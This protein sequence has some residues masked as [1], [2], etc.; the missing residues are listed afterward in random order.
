M[1]GATVV[2]AGHWDPH[3][4]LYRLGTDHQRPKALIDKDICNWDTFFRRVVPAC[5]DDEQ[6]QLLREAEKTAPR[7]GVDFAYR[8]NMAT[9]FCCPSI[10]Y[11]N[12]LVVVQGRATGQTA[13]RPRS[14]SVC[15]PPNMDQPGRLL[16]GAIHERALPI[17]ALSIPLESNK[18]RQNNQVLKQLTFAG[19]KTLPSALRKDMWRPLFTATFPSPSQGLAAFR[20]LRELRMLHEHNWEHPDPDARKLPEK[21]ER[22]RLIMD[23]KANSIA[24]LAW[25]LRGQE[26]LGVKMAEKHEAN[27]HRIREEL[28]ALSKEAEEGGV[29][30]LEQTLADQQ[31]TID[32]MKQMQQQG[33]PD[34]PSRKQ[35]GEAILVSKQMRLRLEK[36]RAA[37]QAIEDAKNKAQTQFETDDA[38]GS[39][40]DAIS[41]VIEPPR[42]FS[43]PPP[44]LSS[45]SKK[46]K[47]SEQVPLYTTEGVIIRWTNPL[48]AEF[49]AEWPAAVQHEFAGLAR[50]TA[51]PIDQEPAFSVE[52]M[53]QRNTSHKY[54]AMRDA[55]QGQVEE[56][57]EGVEDVDAADYEQ[58]TEKSAD[59]LAPARQ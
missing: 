48:D 59:G 36:M 17:A 24:D 55:R 32:N 37:S 57:S 16:T 27:Q 46:S 33:G 51:A 47:S 31:A 30:L 41:L 11:H 5:D 22:G 13:S 28:L 18:V 58:V 1:E 39:A 10:A 54:T 14:P 4:A 40:P 15:L 8:M 44:E 26:E 43:H 9:L 7:P 42:I 38:R 3:L 35:I 12:V 29:Q 34:A 52:D 45:K 49:A 50:H 2:L 53:I 56:I 25:V 6:L 19:K 21:K 23:Q 20:K